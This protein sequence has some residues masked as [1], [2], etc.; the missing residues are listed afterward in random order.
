MNKKLLIIPLFLLF[1]LTGCSFSKETQN[2]DS[3]AIPEISPATSDQP[4]DRQSQEMFDILHELAPE[5]TELA[6][7]IEEKSNGQAHLVM[8]I[9]R[10]LNYISE[11]EYERDYYRI[12]V[13]ESHPTH[14]VNLHRF[15]IYKNLHLKKV[16]HVDPITLEPETLEEWRGKK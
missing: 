2:L 12:Y 14:Q 11:D 16:L 5:L 6:K 7:Q 4:I 15:L 10:E 8:Y 3:P 13:G 1:F 9:E